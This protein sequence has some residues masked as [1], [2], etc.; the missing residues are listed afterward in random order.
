MKK[1]TRY[2]G[3]P[4][5]TGKR[6]MRNL[7]EVRPRARLTVSILLAV[8][9]AGGAPPLLADENHNGSNSDWLL[10]PSFQV[11]RRSA[12]QDAAP[13]D[14]YEHG[15]VDVLFSHSAGPFR[16]LA[17]TEIA[18]SEVEIERFQV[19]WELGENTLAWAGRFQQPSSAWNTEH[20]HGQYLQTAI[21][22]PNIELWEGEGGL[23]PQHVAGV[24]VDSHGSLGSD[25]GL[26]FAVGGGAAP[27][28]RLGQLEPVYVL[29]GNNG[30]HRASWSGRIAYQPELLGDDSFGLLLAQHDVNVVDPAVAAAFGANDVTLDVA[31]AFAKLVRDDWRVQA[32]F[33]HVGARFASGPRP[34]SE[35]FGDGYL[36]V[37]RPLSARWTP[38]ARLEV[39]ANAAHSSY[40]A[41]QS[42]EFETRRTLA[43]LRWDVWRNQALTVEVGHA[44]T[45][46]TRFSDVRLQWSCVLP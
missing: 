46:V 1:G 21:A 45:L 28:L 19:G 9:L 42:H 34:R 31:G 15:T 4:R 29:R 11:F 36:Q 3:V 17:E 18:A 33:Y 27:I 25:G 13:Q 35:S 6:E 43:G 5:L 40:V 30:G 7:L 38:Y 41:F 32:A 44:A 26:T 22:R 20:H 2:A 39:S 23:M 14:D 10:F 8:G 37:E 16:A 24:L 12:A